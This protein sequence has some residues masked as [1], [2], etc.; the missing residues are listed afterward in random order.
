MPARARRRRG[1]EHRL[2]STARERARR[3]PREWRAEATCARSASSAACA[4]CSSSEIRQRR[5]PS[6]FECSCAWR[7]LGRHRQAALRCK[8]SRQSACSRPPAD[9]QADR[10]AIGGHVG[11]LISFLGWERT[12]GTSPRNGRTCSRGRPRRRRRGK[13]SRRHGRGL[14]GGSPRWTAAARAVALRK[15]RR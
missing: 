4:R 7:H 1:A 5:D 6:G 10:H 9:R 13:A 15:T 14:P 2:P 8:I 3:E 11:T 12:A